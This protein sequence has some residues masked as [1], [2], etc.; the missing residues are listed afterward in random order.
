MNKTLIALAIASVATA[1]SAQS[2]TG[3]LKLYGLADIGVTHVT[4]FKGGSATTLNSGIMEGSRW[5]LK[6]EE[7]MGNGYK[8]LFTLES[9]LELDNGTNSNRPYSGSQGPDRLTAGL[10]DSLA[11]QL[12]AGLGATL[13]VNHNAKKTFDRQAYV[14][15]VTPVG[16]FLAGRMYTPAYEALAT[17]DIMQTQSSLSAGQL[18]SIP[19]GIDIRHD[20]ALQY[21]IVKGP[22]QAAFMTARTPAD[23]SVGI[24]KST[25]SGYNA[26]YKSDAYSFGIGYNTKDNSAKQQ[27]LKNLG[28]GASATMNQWTVSALHMRLK[29]PNSASGPELQSQLLMSPIPIPVSVINNVLDRLKQEARLSHIGLRYNAGAAGMVTVAYNQYDD[30]R[31]ADADAKS[32]GVAYT[33]PLSKRTNL[34]AV[35]TRYLN[36]ANSQIAPGGNGYLG[37]VTATAG[38]DATSIALGVRHTF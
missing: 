34:N 24:N 32:F 38:R 15:L 26:M 23:P 20:D 13:G 22:W 35:A 25:F 7:D 2:D 18:V 28:L 6:G 10:P 9:R 37:G 4:G 17:F 11:D 19:S 12:K 31:A 36:S 21:R 1:A 33:Y 29:E 30:R 8:A 5:G 27:S 16:G 14:G 3:S